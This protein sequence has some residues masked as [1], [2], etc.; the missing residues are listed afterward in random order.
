MSSQK[1]YKHYVRK[2]V[3]GFFLISAIVKLFALS[4]L[5]DLMYAL[6]P[7]NWFGWVSD[8]ILLAGLLFIVLLEII[9]GLLLWI[10]VK[11]SKVMTAT[12]AYL[13]FMS[14]VNG[15]QLWVGVADCGCLGGWIQLPP[16][17][18][19]AKTFVLLGLTTYLKFAH[20]QF[21]KLQILSTYKS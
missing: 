16:T 2:G 3:S 5:K 14:G 4:Y 19:I 21:G 1:L 7:I 11:S 9:L 13:I 15:Y 17:V 20:Y 6:M 18:T 10:G 12:I 8:E